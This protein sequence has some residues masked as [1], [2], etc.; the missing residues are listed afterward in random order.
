MNVFPSP[1]TYAKQIKEANA[2]TN[3]TLKKEK[4]EQ[5]QQSIENNNSKIVTS[6]DDLN[7]K[8]VK[9]RENADKTAAV[10]QGSH[11][12]KRGATSAIEDYKTVYELSYVR[13][14]TMILGFV[15]LATFVVKNWD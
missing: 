15:G 12:E 8:I 4:L 1:L 7:A 2:E 11:L 6:I 3:E 5:I 9:M 10:F 14:I 13:N